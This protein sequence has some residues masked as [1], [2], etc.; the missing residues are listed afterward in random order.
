VRVKKKFNRCSKTRCGCRLASWNFIL[1]RLLGVGLIIYIT[2]HGC[3]KGTIDESG[4]ENIHTVHSNP[5]T[6]VKT[7]F[8]SVT[9]FVLELVTSYH[10][11]ESECDR[12]RAG[13]VAI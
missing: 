1:K 4:L 6:N 5:F 13:R 3:S 8:R 2:V 9:D 12:M 7:N 11:S 10:Y